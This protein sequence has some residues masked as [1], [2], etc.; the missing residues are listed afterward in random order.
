[1]MLELGKEGLRV[2]QQASIKVHYGTQIVG[3][4]FADLVVENKVIVELKAARELVKEHEAQLLHY[5]KATCYEVGLLLNF[6]IA[7]QINAK[8]S[9][10]SGKAQWRGQNNQ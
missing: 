5:L 4:Y 7:P 6:G 1:M 10:T 3:E 8:R 2:E 9:T